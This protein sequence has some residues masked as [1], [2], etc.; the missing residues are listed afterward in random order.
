MEKGSFLNRRTFIASAVSSAVFFA[1]TKSAVADVLDDSMNEFKLRLE[2]YRSSDNT[3]KQ[4]SDHTG[5]TWNAGNMQKFQELAMPLL[6]S[7]LS[8]EN[9]RKIRVLIEEEVKSAYRESEQTSFRKYNSSN[10]Q[11]DNVFFWNLE[12]R[13]NIWRYSWALYDSRIKGQFNFNSPNNLLRDLN[14]PLSQDN[15]A[16]VVKDNNDIFTFVYY[17]GWKLKYIMPC[18]PWTP[19]LWSTPTSWLAY[20][21]YRDVSHYYL[22]DRYKDETRRNTALS[23]WVTIGWSMPYSHRIL[24]DD[25]HDGYYTHIGDVNGKEASHGC[26]RLPAFWAYIMFYEA[27]T[28]AN[29]Y[30]KPDYRLPQEA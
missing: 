6:H 11:D 18:S 2:T 22:D 20:G 21:D 28:Q 7:W 4:T 8:T 16:F 30:Y 25:A 1:G 12:S 17:K 13:A 29:V 24:V 10:I 15:V 5:H 14:L 9:M 23:Q 26:I 3:P 19:R 27:D